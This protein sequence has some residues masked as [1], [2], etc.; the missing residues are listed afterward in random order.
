MVFKFLFTNLFKRKVTSLIILN[1]INRKCVQFFLTI[2]KI[3]LRTIFVLISAFSHKINISIINI[4]ALRFFRISHFSITH[5]YRDF[6]NSRNNAET[7]TWYIVLICTH[8]SLI[9]AVVNRRERRWRLNYYHDMH[10]EYLIDER[11]I[12]V[13]MCTSLAARTIGQSPPVGTIK[14]ELICVFVNPHRIPK[15]RSAGS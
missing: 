9:R 14:P 4:L 5:K 12:H 3:F 2:A 7:F 8:I 10:R 11:V 6:S 15:R 13:C 1:I